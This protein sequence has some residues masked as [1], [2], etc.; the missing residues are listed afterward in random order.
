MATLKKYRNWEKLGKAAGGEKFFV[1]DG[2]ALYGSESMFASL[3]VNL[4]CDECPVEK[5]PTELF[6]GYPV[7]SM[8]YPP[9][10]CSGFTLKG[11]A[12]Y[13]PS[14]EMPEEVSW[15][16]TV[17]FK[18]DALWVTDNELCLKVHMAT[19]REH[20]VSFV[21]PR[22]AAKALK[23]AT[24]EVVAYYLDDTSVT[25]EF[26]D[27]SRFTFKMVE[28]KWP[29]MTSWF[30]DWVNL[31]YL[32]EV[33]IDKILAGIDRNGCKYVSF[34]AHN[35]R[36]AD[37]EGNI[38]F[39][40]PFGGIDLGNNDV[41]TFPAKSL[42]KVMRLLKSADFGEFEPSFDARYYPFPAMFVLCDKFGRIVRGMLNCAGA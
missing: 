32:K 42:K 22:D 41:I 15:M 10:S 38:F 25:L 29:D 36:A 8:D 27:Q 14:P 12:D 4:I 16:N 23:S 35:L 34:D 2:Q 9:C 30:G 37:K 6:H 39:S 1:V 40:D 20:T 3:P 13:L 31:P 33:T 17:L 24:S 26:V 19:E 5:S 21:I 7:S 11:V 28:N 18:D